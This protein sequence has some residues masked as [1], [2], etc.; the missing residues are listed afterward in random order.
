MLSSMRPTHLRVEPF[1]TYLAARKV[2]ATPVVRAGDLIFVCGLP[3]FDPQTGEVIRQPIERQI[4]IVLD[5]LKRCVEAAGSSL[6]QVVKCNVYC[7][8]ESHFA[9]FNEAYARYFSKQPPARIF[10]LVPRWPGPFDLEID[11]VAMV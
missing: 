4:Q 2:P 8:D 3:P 6:E 9:T 10:I 5:Q 11:C 7:T 1:S